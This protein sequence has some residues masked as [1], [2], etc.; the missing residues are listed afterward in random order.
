MSSPGSLNKLDGVFGVVNL[1]NFQSGREPYHKAMNLPSTPISDVHVWQFL[2]RARWRR[3]VSPTHQMR[4]HAH[5]TTLSEQVE[6]A[7]LRDYGSLREGQ[8]RFE[9]KWY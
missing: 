2:F 8:I 1:S 9:R 3:M 7:Q 5:P 4:R 6:Q